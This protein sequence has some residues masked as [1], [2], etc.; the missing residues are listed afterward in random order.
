MMEYEIERKGSNPNKMTITADNKV[1][2]KL[3]RSVEG[4]KKLEDEVINRVKQVAEFISEHP[5]RPNQTLRAAFKV[6][7]PIIQFVDGN[8]K[9]I[10]S[11]KV[12]HG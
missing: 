8:A 12:P 6:E 10:W 3:S 5:E 1:R 9:S 2:I 11:V 7:Y 4:D